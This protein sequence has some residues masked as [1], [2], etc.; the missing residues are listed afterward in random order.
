MTSLPAKTLQIADR[1]VLREG[2]KADLIIF[3][4]SKIREKATYPNPF[5]FAEGFDLVIINGKIARENGTMVERKAGTILKPAFATIQVADPMHVAF[6]RRLDPIASYLYCMKHIFASGITCAF[7]QDYL[8][9]SSFILVTLLYIKQLLGRC[10][11]R[12]QRIWQTP[13]TI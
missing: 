7:S 5:Q 3:D 1:G 11:F 2:M 6:I 9:Y 12:Q 13:R 10:E 4:P 8:R